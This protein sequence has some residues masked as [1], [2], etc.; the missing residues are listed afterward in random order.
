MNDQLPP[1]DPTIRD[2]LARRA[3]GRLPGA[4]LGDVSVALNGAGGMAGR[5]RWRRR[6]WVV[7]RLA[8]AGLAVVLVAA[9][10]I[11]TVIPAHSGPAG[12][13][14]G[15]PAARPLTTSELA[16]IM[17]GPALPANT[18]L[19]AEVT[20]DARNDVC[21][22]D[23]YPTLGVVEGMASQVCVMGAGVAAALYQPSTAGIFAFRYLGPGFLG[24]IGE[25]T[26][27]P[28]GLAF[29]AADDWPVTGR[30]FLV[31][32]TLG[33][34]WNTCPPSSPEVGDVLLPEGTDPCS[35]SWLTDDAAAEPSAVWPGDNPLPRTHGEFVDVY[36]ARVIDSIP[37]DG[38]VA[39]VFV[40]RSVVGPCPGDLMTSSRGCA[41]WR[42][43]ALLR[44]VSVPLSRPSPTPSTAASATSA[45]PQ[46]PVVSPSTSLPVAPTGLIGSGG[47]A[48]TAAETSALIAAD[49]SLLVGR[50]MINE[51]VTC[52]GTDCSGV[53]PHAVADLI[54]P[55]GAIGLVGPVEL[56]PDGGL[57][58]T[59]PQILD[60]GFTNHAGALYILDA[61]IFGAAM[62]SCDAPGLACLEVSWLATGEGVAQLN[63]QSEQL[64][65][66]LGAYHEFG[67]GP[68]GGG[69]GL[70][71]LFLVQT[72]W[73]A[74]ACNG[75][76]LASYGSC[77]ARVAIL[78]RLEPA[79]LP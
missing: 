59:V 23:R 49:P 16:A 14:T 61:S 77:S 4:L 2:Q 78:A 13:L 74:K 65:A 35:K 22:M 39:G 25:I 10:A 1:I 28:S 51:R 17:A 24:L 75:Q 76:P 44:D 48:F 8:A 66:Q 70:H 3:A 37:S 40:V 73:G 68:V 62:D 72:A 41:T 29:R 60:A 53:A 43:L 54:Q 5:L 36:G 67:S 47:V 7:P 69:P 20:I 55:S 26:P 63:A 45:A 6:A 30:T 32:A 11:A 56:R 42:V 15:Y 64:S 52:D 21:P 19:V 71:A 18:P 9:V 31:D 33:T 38:L 58:W 27:A 46:T 12:S 50:Y 34:V 79:T 57:V